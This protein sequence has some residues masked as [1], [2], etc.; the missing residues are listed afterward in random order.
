M[1]VLHVIKAT[2]V[3]GAE[4]HLLTLLPG[5]Q[6]QGIDARLLLLVEADKMLAAYAADMQAAGVPVER[7]V[8]RSRHVD[9]GLLL[10]LR[11]FLQ[12][13]Q[14]A[15]VH[16]HLLHADLYALPVAHLAGIKTVSSRHNDDPFRVRFPFK[17]VQQQLSRMSDRIIAI[18]GA[19]GDFVRRQEGAADE[20]VTVIPYGLHFTAPDAGARKVA[21]TALRQELRLSG[22]ALLVG[23]VGRLVEQKG[24]GYGVQ[25][26]ASLAEQDPQAHLVI[27]GDGS[28]RSVLQAEVVGLGLET[29]THFTGW[30]DDVPQMMQ[31]LDVFLMPSLWEGFGLVLLEAMA[32]GIPVVASAVSAI[33]EVVLQGETGLLVPARDVQGLTEALRQLLTDAPLRQHMGLM[34][35]E[36]AET[37]FSAGRMI[38]STVGVYRQVA[39]ER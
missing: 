4:K 38:E 25:A 18:S 19:V 23:M 31:A 6:A 10:W 3:A 12:Q 17:H 34:G 16:T 28:L 26:F 35:Q 21:R 5:L 37:Q 2:G 30:R 24:M 7:Y 39:G 15:L 33:P 1:Q 22:D 11:R 14:P 9:P 20:R 32:A 8:L 27:V 13:V 36:R 29:R